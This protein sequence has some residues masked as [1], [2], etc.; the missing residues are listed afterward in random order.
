MEGQVKY[1]VWQHTSVCHWQHCFHCAYKCMFSECVARV[2]HNS[3]WLQNRSTWTLNPRIPASK[4]NPQGFLPFLR[5]DCPSP[6]KA[7]NL[8]RASSCGE[9]NNMSHH[10]ACVYF[11]DTSLINSKHV[12]IQHIQNKLIGLVGVVKNSEILLTS[13]VIFFGCGLEFLMKVILPTLYS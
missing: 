4:Q 8:L 6:E 7:M 2:K 10:K 11:N 9:C 3:T 1:H 13:S 12:L 5:S